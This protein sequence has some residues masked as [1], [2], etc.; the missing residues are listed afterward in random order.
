MVTNLRADLDDKEFHRFK[1]IKA[2]MAASTNDKAIV[3]LM[4]F[5]EQNSDD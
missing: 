5:Y 2:E 3:G 4:D 1:R